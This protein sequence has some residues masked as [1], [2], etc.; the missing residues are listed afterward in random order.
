MADTQELLKLVLDQVIKL[1]WLTSSLLI[2]TLM[3]LL[4]QIHLSLKKAQQLNL[5]HFL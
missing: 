1:I 3:V 5:K 2:E 4:T